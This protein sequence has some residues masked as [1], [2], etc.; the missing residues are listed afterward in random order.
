MNSGEEELRRVN[1]RLGKNSYTLQT[2][3]DDKTL[4]NIMEAA[5]ETI[6]DIKDRASQEDLLV[7]IC[8][9]FGWKLQKISGRLE[10]LLGRIGNGK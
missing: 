9:T 5:E 2:S 3:L 4:R 7:F 6:Q 1:L 8:L 10:D